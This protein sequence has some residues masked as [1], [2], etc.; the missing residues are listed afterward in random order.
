MKKIIVIIISIIC[1]LSISSCAC[2]SFKREMKSLNSDFSGGLNRTLVLMDYEGDTLKTW[3]GKFD[4][5]D[6]G[7]D[8]QVFF[9]LN[10]KRVWIQGGIVVSE[11]Y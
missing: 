11:E 9:D 7:A 1:L 2:E 4:I 10:G 8:N 3:N 5:R 6:E